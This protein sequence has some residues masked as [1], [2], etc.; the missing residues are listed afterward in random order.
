MRAKKKKSETLVCTGGRAH[1]E[2]LEV[3]EDPL[4]ALLLVGGAGG[5]AAGLRRHG[6]S[7]LRRNPSSPLHATTRGGNGSLSSLREKKKIL[8]ERKETVESLVA[9]W[10]RAPSGLNL[11]F[12]IRTFDASGF[13]RGNP[14]GRTDGGPA[15]SL[16]LTR[17]GAILGCAARGAIKQPRA[18]A[19]LRA[20]SSS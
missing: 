7:S 8:R 4:P 20:S 14:T 17:G 6:S 19:G 1:L 16:Q 13:V 9:F 5:R 2:V 15:G 11:K 10:R 3:L 18:F 12:R